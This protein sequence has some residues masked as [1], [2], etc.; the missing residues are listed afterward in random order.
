MTRR[1]AR[2]RL[3]EVRGGGA[4]STNEDEDE[5]WRPVRWLAGHGG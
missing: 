2:Q 3:E 1:G 5:A 4:E